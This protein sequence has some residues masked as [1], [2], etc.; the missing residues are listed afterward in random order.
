MTLV[1]NE[2]TITSE[3]VLRHTIRGAGSYCAVKG[4]FTL[5]ESE[6]ESELFSWIF[7]AAQCER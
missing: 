1:C 2:T 6:H 4:S 3:T 5:T 7:V